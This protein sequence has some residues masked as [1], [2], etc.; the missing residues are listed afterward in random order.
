MDFNT[1]IRGLFGEAADKDPP[2]ELSGDLLVID[3]RGCA[4]APVPGS[5][6][7]LRCMVRSMCNAGSADRVVLRTGRDIEISGKAG[8]MVKEAASTMRWSIPLVKP[9]GRC[10][11]CPA[12]RDAV[13]RAAWDRFPD[14]PDGAIRAMLTDI[15]DR[16]GCAECAAG[17]ARVLDQI[18]DGIARMTD[19]L[20]AG[21]RAVR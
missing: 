18:G 4:I 6:E 14:G 12:S 9:K 11:M 21:R 2:A 20:R 7:C 1:G 5:N 17:T 16:E 3:C 13:V 15:P 19:S 10:R 8:R